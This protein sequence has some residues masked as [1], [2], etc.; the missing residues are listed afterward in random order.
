MSMRLSLDRLGVGVVKLSEEGSS[1]P[2]E[3]RRDDTQHV[4]AHT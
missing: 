3:E 2:E 4:S 1:L